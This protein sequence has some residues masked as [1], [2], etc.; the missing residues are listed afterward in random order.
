VCG[1]SL[2]PDGQ[3]LSELDCSPTDTAEELVRAGDYRVYQDPEDLLSHLDE[4]G[5]RVSS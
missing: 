3:A 1:T 5:L 2:P 4:I